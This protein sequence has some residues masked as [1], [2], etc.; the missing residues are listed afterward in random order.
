M[1]KIFFK[2]ITLTIISIIITVSIAEIHFRFFLPVEFRSFINSSTKTWDRDEEWFTKLF[3]SSK[4]LGYEPMPNNHTSE[5]ATNSLGMFDKERVKYKPK[6]VYRIICLGDSTTANS[7]YVK[8]LEMLLNKDT[9]KKFEVWNCGVAGY[10]TLQQLRALR[11]KW[12]RYNPDMVIMGFC[13]NDFDTTPIVVKENGNLVGY[14]PHKEILPKVNPFLLKHSAIYRFI[15]ARLLFSKK[16]DNDIVELSRSYIQKTQELLSAKGIQFLIVIL[17]IPERIENSSM[18][19]NYVVVK[20]IIEDYNIEFINIVPLFKKN[21]P[22]S[23]KFLPD[24][25]IHFNREGSQI[26][27]EAIH[28]YLKANLEIMKN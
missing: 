15:I 13:L 26:V 21:N 12:L 16:D 11:H 10:S 24:D 19:E 4:I 5:I 6:S 7:E 20:S 1:N 3:R 22:E 18:K 8:I 9:D 28:E 23:L 14:F 25:N 17:G 2:N 27:A